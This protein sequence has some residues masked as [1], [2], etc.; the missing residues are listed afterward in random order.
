MSETDVEKDLKKFAKAWL[1][2]KGHQD[3]KV[4][5]VM[6]SFSWEDEEGEEFTTVLYSNE[7]TLLRRGMQSIFKEIIG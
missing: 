5:I 1:G 2:R 7:S 4:K 6:M 3:P